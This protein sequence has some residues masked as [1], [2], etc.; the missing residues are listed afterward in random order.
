MRFKEES[1][2]QESPKIIPIKFGS[3]E[4]AQYW[5]SPKVLFAKIL[6]ASKYADTMPKG[7]KNKKPCILAG[8]ELSKNFGSESIKK[9]DEIVQGCIK[10]GLKCKTVVD[11]VHTAIF[12]LGFTS[13]RSNPRLVY[14]CDG[15]GTVED[16]IKAIMDAKPQFE[17]LAKSISEKIAKRRE[18]FANEEKKKHDFISSTLGI[19]LS[20]DDW[21]DLDIST[22]SSM[23]PIPQKLMDAI[24]KRYLTK[25]EQKKVMFARVSV[26]LKRQIVWNLYDILKGDKEK[27]AQLV[28]S[29]RYM[30]DDRW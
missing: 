28:K 15:S 4:I 19:K 8:V 9:I 27:E 22:M 5:S 25:A 10:K 29:L 23:H 13:G 16:F 14:I 18:D 2:S 20:A 17:A 3:K 24:F 7:F 30:L 6:D 26:A 11:S 21:H 1:E 12:K